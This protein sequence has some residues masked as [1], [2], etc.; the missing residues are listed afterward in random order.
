MVAVSN[1]IIAPATRCRAV[2]L[3]AFAHNAD[4]MLASAWIHHRLT[5]RE[6]GMQGSKGLEMKLGNLEFSDSHV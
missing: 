3:L 6:V 4:P 1:R 5:R 2:H